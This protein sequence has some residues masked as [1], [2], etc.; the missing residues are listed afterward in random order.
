ML[1]YD[2]LK[3]ANDSVKIILLLALPTLMLS[4]I[5]GLVVSIFQAVTQ[6]QDVAL[7][8]VPKIIIISVSAVILLPWMVDKISIYAKELYSLIKIF[9]Q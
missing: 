3:I 6:I 8:F 9:G 2:L 4:L 5:I 7:A 1:D